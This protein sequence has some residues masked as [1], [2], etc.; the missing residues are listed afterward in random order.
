VGPGEC[1]AIAKSRELALELSTPEL[2]DA[3]RPDHHED[4]P[5]PGQHAQNVVDQARKVVDDRDRSLVLAKGRA[6]EVSLIH[7]GEEERRP[8]EKLPPIPAREYRRGARGGHD[9]VRRMIDVHG[10]DVVDEGSVGR[11]DKPRRAHDD[12]DDVHGLPDSLVQTYA[13]VA[14][15]VIDDQVPAVQRL[16]HQYLLDHGLR[17]ARQRNGR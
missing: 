11:A 4:L 16:Q 9:E 17:F 14:G 15:E 8:R 1:H 6:A 7:R 10:S 5:R 13:K 3:S 12:L 2:A